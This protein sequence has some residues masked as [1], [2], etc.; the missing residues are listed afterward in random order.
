M[1]NKGKADDSENDS[2]DSVNEEKEISTEE[3]TGSFDK[4]ILGLEQ[5][6]FI[7]ENELMSSYKYEKRWWP[8]RL[9]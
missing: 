8:I 1:L 7:I 6:N 9:N 4:S 3:L 5:R 2:Y